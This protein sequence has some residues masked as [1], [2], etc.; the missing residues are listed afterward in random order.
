MILL[1][2][3]K[4]PPGRAPGRKFILG[5]SPS[6]S[7]LVKCNSQILVASN[8]QNKR[9]YFAFPRVFFFI[10]ILMFFSFLIANTLSGLTLPQLNCFINE[11]LVWISYLIDQ[12]CLVMTCE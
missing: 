5:E 2:K 1:T 7:F 9:Y 3:V 10:L 6:W 12:N 8:Q 4:S 11:F